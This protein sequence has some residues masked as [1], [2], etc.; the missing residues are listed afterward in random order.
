MRQ[1]WQALCYCG[2]THAPNFQLLECQQASQDTNPDVCS[3]A[4]KWQEQQQ[5]SPC[6]SWK[7]DLRFIP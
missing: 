2:A 4:N 6:L 1:S 7:T 5:R 3:A